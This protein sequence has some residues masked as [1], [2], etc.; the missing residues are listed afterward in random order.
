MQ[1]QTGLETLCNECGK[2]QAAQ[3]YYHHDGSNEI[4]FVQWKMTSK[5]YLENLKKKPSSQLIH[6]SRLLRVSYQFGMISLSK[7]VCF[8]R[9]MILNR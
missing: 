4:Y 5:G 2:L 8:A 1:R 9:A 6:G 7:F 3:V